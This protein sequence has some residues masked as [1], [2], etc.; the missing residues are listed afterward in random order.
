[1]GGTI[2]KTTWDT[3]Y[4]EGMQQGMQQ[5]KLDLV[6]ALSEMGISMEILEKAMQVVDSQK[7]SFPV[8]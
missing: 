3:R 4:E 5:G 6:L 8:S 2:I 1:M 7:T